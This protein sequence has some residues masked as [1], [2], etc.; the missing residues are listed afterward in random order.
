MNDIFCVN[1]SYFIIIYVDFAPDSTGG[2]Y[3]VPQSGL[4]TAG[5]AARG[6]SGEKR[7]TVERRIREKGEGKE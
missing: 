4:F 3:S 6:E 2:A 1:L 7:A 5:F